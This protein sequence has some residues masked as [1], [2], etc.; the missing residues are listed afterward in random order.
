[1]SS[2]SSSSTTS[3][4]LQ[5]LSRQQLVQA[6]VPTGNSGLL[7]LDKVGGEVLWFDSLSYEITHRLAVRHP[8][9]M[10]I[11]PDHRFAVVSEFGLFR[12]GRNVEPGHHLS[13]VSIAE[14]RTVSRIDL[15]A[16]AGPHGSRWDAE[17]RLWVVCEETG[18]LLRVNV[19]EARVEACLNIAG[20]GERAHLVEIT[21]DAALLFV[22]CKNGPVKVVDLAAQ[23]LAGSIDVGSG[24]EGISC[25]GQGRRIVAAANVAQD[26][27]VIDVQ[28]LSLID[29]VPLRGAVLSSP[30]RSRLVSLQSS[31][32][33]AFLLSSNGVGG[34]VHIHDA[35]DL[36]QQQLVLV[37]KGPQ[38]M[39]VTADGSAF[40]VANHDAGVAT[41]VGLKGANAGKPLRC[42]EAGK[43]VEALSFYQ[44]K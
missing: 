33:G 6:N 39:A 5:R 16:N 14:H 25:I 23:A 24:T 10:S 2:S 28:S 3:I 20:P 22:A 34:S 32:D 29:R 43:G 15:G 31:P 27:V 7:A 37:A 4:S 41:L 21:P 36:R 30:R 11:T 26:L 17:G 8:H 18:T 44:S 35:D 38:G 19:E 1:M 40:V 9:Q 12:E 13:V 42:F